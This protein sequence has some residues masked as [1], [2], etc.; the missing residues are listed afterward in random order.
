MLFEIPNSK[1]ILKD[2]L[3][4]IGN[5]TVAVVTSA[6][7]W[8]VTLQD[9]TYNGMRVW[10]LPVMKDRAPALAMNRPQGFAR[11]DAERLLMRV[12]SAISWVHGGGIL[13]EHFSGGSRCFLTER[14]Q[15]D[16]VAIR[17]DFD[18][19]YLPEPTDKKAQLALALMRGARDQPRSLRLPI[20]LQG[21]AV[22]LSNGKAR[23][24]WISDHIEKVR[25]IPAKQAVAELKASGVADIGE[26]L[27]KS[28]RHAI[29]HAARDPIINPDDPA[30]LRRLHGETPNHYVAGR[31]GG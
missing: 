1:D 24:K 15:R 11:E 3:A 4:A 26:H 5:W 29:A 22:S 28:G 30:D 12:A 8:P 18:L 16:V 27:A 10:V 9:F 25:G 2:Q 7:D 6:R 19:S 13:I 23:T 21:L 14:R 20:V 17:K 31:T